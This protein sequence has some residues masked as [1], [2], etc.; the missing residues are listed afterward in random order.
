MACSKS[1][2]TDQFRP[3]QVNSKMAMKR[4]TPSAVITTFDAGKFSRGGSRQPQ[5][6]TIP[7]AK[8]WMTAVSLHASISAA[9]NAARAAVNKDFFCHALQPDKIKPSVVATN[10]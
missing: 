7:S 8:K 3:N 4:K 9:E 5:M 1:A 6:I 10:K 2:N